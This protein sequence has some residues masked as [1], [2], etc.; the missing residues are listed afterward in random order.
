MFKKF[1]FQGN[2]AQLSKMFF[3]H[4]GLLLLFITI[5]SHD[6]CHMS[7]ESMIST[8]ICH[9]MGR[10]EKNDLTHYCRALTVWAT[11]LC[12]VVLG[13]HYQWKETISR[14]YTLYNWNHCL[15]YVSCNWKQGQKESV[16]YVLLC[17]KIQCLATKLF[18]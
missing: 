13:G 6:V 5:V 16:F 7:S 17:C 14:G 1:K 10:V 9:I 15:S 3:D 2:L 4:C 8:G 11:L 12:E 18:L